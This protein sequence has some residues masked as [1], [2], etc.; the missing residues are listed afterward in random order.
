MEEQISLGSDHSMSAQRNGWGFPQIGEKIHSIEVGLC[1]IAL[2]K[3]H[4]S[5]HELCSAPDLCEEEKLTEL[6]LCLIQDEDPHMI[7]RPF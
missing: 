2:R 3:N 1:G 4:R 6:G 5:K 7:R